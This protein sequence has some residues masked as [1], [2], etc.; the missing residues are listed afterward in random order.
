MVFP[1]KNISLKA[2]NN[3][4]SPNFVKY[5]DLFKYDIP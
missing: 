3:I 5:V 2:G 1:L 4:A